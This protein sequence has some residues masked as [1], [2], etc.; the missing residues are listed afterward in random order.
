M[1]GFGPPNVFPAQRLGGGGALPHTHGG[2]PKAHSAGTVTG[3]SSTSVEI[4]LA[5]CNLKTFITE[6]AESF[7]IEMLKILSSYWKC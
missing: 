1:K 6:R 3:E 5:S 4:E 7:K 2:S